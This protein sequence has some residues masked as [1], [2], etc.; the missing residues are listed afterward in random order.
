MST[1][2]TEAWI[3]LVS[4]KDTTKIR[5]YVY[6]PMARAP[7]SPAILT[8]P[9]VGAISGSGEPVRELLV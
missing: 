1:V 2:G 5:E 7:D 4:V 6:K 3:F 8:R 9:E